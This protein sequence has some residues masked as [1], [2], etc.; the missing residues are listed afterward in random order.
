[1]RMRDEFSHVPEAKEKMISQLLEKIRDIELPDGWRINVAKSSIVFTSPK[2][3][4]AVTIG[5][6][7]RVVLDVINL[8][9]VKSSSFTCKDFDETWATAHTALKA[10]SKGNSV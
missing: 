8:G 7:R 9:A 3:T 2:R 4:R 6:D 1:M 5:T 10:F